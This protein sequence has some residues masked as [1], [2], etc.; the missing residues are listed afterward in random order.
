MES[1]TNLVEQNLS[2]YFQTQNFE[3]EKLTILCTSSG[4]LLWRHSSKCL[5][6]SNEGEN[7]PNIPFLASIH[8]FK[9]SLATAP[10]SVSSTKIAK[11]AILPAEAPETLQIKLI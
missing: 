1:A 6:I 5:L 2:S 11:A 3:I 7:G 10:I 9:I 8:R 4:R